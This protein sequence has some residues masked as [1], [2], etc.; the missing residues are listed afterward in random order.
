MVHFLIMDNE[1]L[2]LFL[3]IFDVNTLHTGV[4]MVYPGHL[5][6]APHITMVLRAASYSLIS[7]HVIANVLLLSSSSIILWKP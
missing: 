5:S 3:N 2:A 1:V 4:D 7:I 6:I